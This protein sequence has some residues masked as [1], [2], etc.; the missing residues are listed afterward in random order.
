MDAEK[1]K[2]FIYEGYS[3][4][5]TV[6][7]GVEFRLN[8]KD[9]TGSDRDEL[10]VWIPPSWIDYFTELLGDSYFEDG[11]IECRLVGRGYLYVD[12]TDLL[13][14]DGLQPS[15]VLKSEDYDDV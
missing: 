8:R 15:D 12:I 11:G 2:G 7:G 1:W 9:D 6:L 5:D 14:A 13:E 3:D 4:D 10:A